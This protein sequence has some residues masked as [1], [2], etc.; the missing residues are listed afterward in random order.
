MRFMFIATTRCFSLP[1]IISRRLHQKISHFST[2]SESSNLFRRVRRGTN[3]RYLKPRTTTS[4]RSSSKSG[5][6]DDDDVLLRASTSCVDFKSAL[7]THCD[8][9]EEDIVRVYSKHP[10]VASY[11]VAGEIVPRINYLKFLQERNRLGN[12]DAKEVTYYSRFIN[13]F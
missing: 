7:K 10:L 13:I 9:T 6:D 8:F 12:E 1:I 5:N 3:P 2:T 4:M 11:D